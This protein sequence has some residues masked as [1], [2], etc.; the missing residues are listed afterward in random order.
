MNRAIP[1]LVGLGLL[2]TGP[3]V[4]GQTYRWV[5]D[6][7]VVV[8]SDQPP[9]VRLGDKERDALIAEAL[10]I[11]GTK[12]ALESL[13]AQNPG[14]VGGRL[15][16]HPR[17][18]RHRALQTRIRPEDKARVIRILT[19]AFRLDVLYSAVRGAFR[20]NFDAERMDVVM[21]KLRSPLFRKIAAMELAATEPGARQDL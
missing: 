16:P 17:S 9:Q 7:G 12:K 19:D 3:L 2:A 20:S 4:E 13:P 11:S 18:H 6:Q 15:N 21:E 8:Y 10:E 1:L 14:H 5:N